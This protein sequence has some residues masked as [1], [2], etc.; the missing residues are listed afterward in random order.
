MSERKEDSDNTLKEEEKDE[1]ITNIDLLSLAEQRA[2]S[3]PI[4][5]FG[6]NAILTIDT[7]LQTRIERYWRVKLIISITIQDQVILG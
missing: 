7:V 4:T 1:L 5:D 3:A 6:V 2:A